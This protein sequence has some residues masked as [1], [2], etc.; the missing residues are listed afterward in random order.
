MTWLTLLCID[1]LT[2]QKTHYFHHYCC[3]SLPVLPKH[4]SFNKAHRSEKNII[5]LN[6]IE[7]KNALTSYIYV[8]TLLTHY[9]HNLYQLSLRKYYFHE[10]EKLL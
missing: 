10:S 4:I 3:S 5:L 6:I 1:A 8:W 7:H 9:L 2:V